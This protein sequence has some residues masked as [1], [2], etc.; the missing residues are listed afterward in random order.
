MGSWSGRSLI[1]FGLLWAASIQQAWAV[2]AFCKLNYTTVVTTA[3]L[4]TTLPAPRDVPNGYVLYD[5]QWI[6]RPA[7]DVSCGGLLQH[8][9]LSMT[10]GF[11]NGTS[12][13]GFSDVYPTGV[14]GVGIK[15][16]WSRKISPIPS[17]IEGGQFMA[18]PMQ[19]EPLRYSPFKPPT[20]FT[21]A[22]HW[23]FQ[24][25]KTGNLA[26]GNFSIPSIQV[27]YGNALTNALEFSRGSLA[28]NTRGCSLRTKDQIVNLEKSWLKDFRGIGSTTRPKDFDVD[29]QCESDIAVSYR[30]DGL[31]VDDS[32]LKNS[33]GRD[34]ATGVGIQL[35][36]RHGFVG[37]L[38]LGR[39]VLL[40]RTAASGNSVVRIPLTA[41]YRQVD[42]A[43]G[44][45]QVVAAATITLFYR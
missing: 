34:M 1:L 28:L 5:S 11:T 32:T 3:P 14:P 45:G 42:S 23:R 38:A 33:E 18:S 30:I 43:V 8:G 25:I 19:S 17:N 37:P 35:L 6:V 4:P 39:E 15:V 12:V 9:Q 29:L 41:R 27:W 44:P 13:P 16:A 31:K 24:L 22:S 2:V 21:P 10:Y 7:G 36:S 26:S 40:G 20:Q